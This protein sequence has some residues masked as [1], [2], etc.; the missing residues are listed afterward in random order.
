M[1]FLAVLWILAQD[2]RK[3][4]EERRAVLRD[5]KELDAWC[6]LGDWASG[7]DLKDQAKTC[8]QEAL[9]NDPQSAR[10]CEGMRTLGYEESDGKWL[11]FGAL[12]SAKKARLKKDD[13]HGLLE[14][15]QWCRL[16][17]MAKE[18][19]QALEAVLKIEPFHRIAHEELGYRYYHGEWLSP[20][21]FEKELKV[22]EIWKE[23]LAENRPASDIRDAVRRAGGSWSGAPATVLEKAKSPGPG[24]YHDTKLELDRDKFPGEYTY[25]VPGDYVPWRKTPMIVFLHGGGQ[26]AGDGD[27]YFPTAW[28]C[29]QPRGCILVCPT[30]LKKVAVAWSNEQHVGYIRSIVQEMQKKY[31]VDPDRVYLWG[32]SMG[33][34]GVFYIGTR[35]ADVFAA[36]SPMS[37]GPMGWIPDNLKKTP[38]RIVHGD[39]DDVVPPGG[40]RKAAKMLRERGATVIYDEL[41]GVKHGIPHENYD[42][43]ADWFLTLKRS[44]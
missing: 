41:P 27:D 37:G 14:L 1:W 28:R 33:G 4:F 3:E 21:A 10:A 16:H 43:V 44:K 17:E 8:Y 23:A 25:A 7:K 36:I 42:K 40:S 39:A 20:E 30:V 5:S 19:R 24:T 11:T 18:R 13:V 15:A 2:P 38:V 22:D 31:N 12:Y 34:F 9:K 6:E 29:A 35:T 26:G 32:H